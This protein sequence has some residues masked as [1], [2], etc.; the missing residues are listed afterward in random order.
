[1][2]LKQRQI[3]DI[4][5]EFCN[6]F[7]PQLNS[8]AHLTVSRFFRTFRF[9]NLKKQGQIKIL[10][11]KNPFF[12]VSETSVSQYCHCTC[13]GVCDLQFALK[14]DFNNILKI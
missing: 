13:F 11:I 9:C 5:S 12:P 1:M 3:G 7:N 2:L 4:I 6:V 14:V 10:L 8:L